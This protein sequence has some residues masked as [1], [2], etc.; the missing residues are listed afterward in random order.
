MTTTPFVAT[1]RTR[2]EVVRLPTAG[3][4]AITIRVELPET[5]DVVRVETSPTE[6]ALAVKTTALQSR[7]PDGDPAQEFVLKLR[8]W[9][10]LDESATLADLGVINGSILLLTYRRRRPV[11]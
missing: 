5:W 9:D 3:P 11:R 7:L 10:I 6:T 1:L 8:G 2:Q 4:D